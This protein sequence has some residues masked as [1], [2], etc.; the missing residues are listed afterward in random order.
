MNFDLQA[1][2][3][4]LL[5]WLY[6]HSAPN[7]FTPLNE[8]LRTNGLLDQFLGGKFTKP[9]MDREVEY[10]WD[11]GLITTN[12]RVNQEV[13]GWFYPCLTPDASTASPSTE[14]PWPSSCAPATVVPTTTSPRT[15]AQRGE[16][17]LRSA[18][19]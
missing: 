12:T 9:E 17:Q 7:E 1:T 3:Q 19:R 8:F 5:D 14:D 13:N 6:D 4:A 10:L 18:V 15:A 11:R 16:Q 2:G